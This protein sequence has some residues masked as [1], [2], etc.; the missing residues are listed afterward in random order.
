MPLNRCKGRFI[1]ALYKFHDDDDD[2]D[3]K[4]AVTFPPL[5]KPKLVL[6]RM[7]GWVAMVGVTLQDSLP[8]KTI[9]YLRNVQPSNF[10]ANLIMCIWNKK[11]NH[12]TYLNEHAAHSDFS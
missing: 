3:D 12:F 11:I 9:T 8:I 6:G 2:D 5:A 1:K 4:A 10:V 7:Q